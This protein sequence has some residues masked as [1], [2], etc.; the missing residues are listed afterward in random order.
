MDLFD[1]SLS[2]D[3]RYDM[4]LGGIIVDVNLRGID[5]VNVGSW[6]MLDPGIDDVNIGSLPPSCCGASRDPLGAGSSS[7]RSCKVE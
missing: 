2:Y 6:Q 4:N 3:M 1:Y 5:D 7:T